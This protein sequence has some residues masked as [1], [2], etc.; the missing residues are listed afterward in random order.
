MVSWYDEKERFIGG[1]GPNASD[2]EVCFFQTDKVA[3]EAIVE[4]LET[5]H[6]RIRSFLIETFQITDFM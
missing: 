5:L 2:V 4:E 6:V 1:N 3:I